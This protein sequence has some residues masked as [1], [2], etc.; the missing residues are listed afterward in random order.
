LGLAR[1]RTSE[2]RVDADC[3]LLPVAIASVVA[4]GFH[5]K[6]KVDGWQAGDGLEAAVLSAWRQ[7]G[8]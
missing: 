8:R 1:G 4:D 7:A 5:V 3:Q 2:I 6:P